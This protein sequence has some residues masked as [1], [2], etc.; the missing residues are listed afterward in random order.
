MRSI[1]GKNVL[2]TGG[3]GFIGSYLVDLLLKKEANRVVVLDNFFLGKESN[4]AIARQYENFVVYKDDARHFGV[5]LSIMQKESIDAVFNMA[6][7]ALK[8]SF[9]NPLDAYMLNVEIMNSLLSLLKLQTYETLVHAS[10]SEAYGTGLYLPMD[11]NHPL[12]PTTP[13]AGG[14]ASADLMALSLYKVHPDLDISIVRPFN[15]YGPRQNDG[16]LAAI[17]PL[18]A[19]KILTG[20]KPV[21]EGDG[22]QTRDFLYVEDTASAFLMA[23]ENPKAIGKVINIGT[24]FEMSIKDVVMQIA[25]YYEYKGDIEY[26]PARTSD[27]KRLCAKTTLADEILGFRAATP[28]DKGLAA[29]L[30]WFRQGGINGFAL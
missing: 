3:A 7:I 19:K 24:G 14:K 17:I 11:E 21:I 26:H 18:V 20:G 4:L 12:N 29:T 13:Y 22:S 2:V 23:Y 15:N 30:E 27:V 5:L 1:K 6:T 9:I 10:T 16:F 8:Y 28:F 25:D